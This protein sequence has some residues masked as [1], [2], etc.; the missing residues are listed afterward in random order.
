MPNQL[1]R[2][3]L[4]I[5]DLSGYTHYM[6]SIDLDGSH[7]VS[8]LLDTIATALHPFEVVKLEGDAV[9]CRTAEGAVSARETLSLITRAYER[10][11]DHADR[12]TNESGCGCQA[13]HLLPGLG[14][15]FVVHHGEYAVH[16]IAGYPELV[17]AEVIVAHRLLKNTVG[18]Q[19]GHRD[20]VLLTR[21]WADAVG[22]DAR[23]L[24]GDAHS[25]A[26]A[27]IGSVECVVVNLGADDGGAVT[28]GTGRESAA[29]SRCTYAGDG[30]A[31][32]QSEV[33]VK[34]DTKGAR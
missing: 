4:L 24:G 33:V 17:G 3:P 28:L 12:I 7:V 20:Y 14:L 9:F 8:E 32:S 27:H 1:E 31:A 30:L 34:L 25:E 2:G 6:A 16:R 13:C 29:V 18:T 5:A 26:Y 22:L 11:I 15:K 19:W 21:Q 23:T 10:F